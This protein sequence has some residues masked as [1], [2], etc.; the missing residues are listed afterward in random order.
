MKGRNPEIT[1]FMPVY[2]AE[3]YLKEAIDSILNQTFENFE[4][5]IIN[6]GSTD[7]SARIVEEYN[8]SRI[9]LIHNE[10]NKG[11]P[12][13]RNR[14]LE[15]ACGKYLAIMDAD[16]VSVPDRLQIQYDTMEA[17]P[18]LTVV[19]SGKELLSDTGKIT[20]G[21]KEKLFSYLFHGKPEEICIDLIFHNILVNSST[22]TRLD[23]VKKH[24]IIYNSK[25]VVMQDYEFWTQICAKG[26]KIR[27]IR[28]P[29]VMYREHMDNI[30]NHTRSKKADLRKEIQIGIQKKYLHALGFEINDKL[31]NW[32]KIYGLEY[33][34]MISCPESYN[35]DQ[36]YLFYRYIIEHLRKTTAL[37]KKDVVAYLRKRYFLRTIKSPVNKGVYIKKIKTLK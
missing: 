13:T 19:A 25:C 16:D 7:D 33:E 37:R 35:L 8:D 5:L 21:L 26:G 6:D 24:N 23:F 18:D 15:L 34:E 27:I 12:Y 22:M 30:T 31:E 28:K 3:K 20:Y 36:L 32:L 10:G 11:L 9:R 17:N 14:G 2:N 4:L 1:V 29:L